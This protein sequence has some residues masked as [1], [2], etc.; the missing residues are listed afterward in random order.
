MQ[1]SRRQFLR[2]DFFGSDMPLRPPWALREREF[3]QH[4]TRCDACNDACPAGIIVRGQDGFPEVDFARGECTFCG[5]CV[6]ACEAG[7]L[8]HAGEA[9]WSVKARID[10]ACIA[11]KQVV[12]RSCGDAC[13]ARAIRFKLR[14]GGSAAPEL[15]I[16]TCTGCGACRGACPVRAISMRHTEA[17]LTA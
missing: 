6:Q 10:A 1:A 13:G 8:R 2:G 14:A 5:D 12:C 15:D 11:L 9:A 17:E 7:A 16:E 4:C 3:T